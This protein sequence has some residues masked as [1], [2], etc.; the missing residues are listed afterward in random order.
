[1]PTATTTS[2]RAIAVLVPASVI[3]A[4]RG[5]CARLLAT[6]RVTLGPGI[7]TR[8]RVGRRKRRYRSASIARRSDRDATVDDEHLARG[9]RALVGRQID[10][11][12]G[13]FL[14]RA[15][16]AHR[17]P[18]DEVAARRFGVVERRDPLVERGALDRA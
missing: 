6:R 18:G 15:E 7:R 16:P 1:M 2:C 11:D 13:D 4:R 3:S 10:R 17:L 8:T 9:V 14:G 12:R 5:P